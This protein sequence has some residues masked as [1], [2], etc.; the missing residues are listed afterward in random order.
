VQTFAKDYPVLKHPTLT[1]KPV[2]T[3][4][5][6]R[7]VSNEEVARLISVMVPKSS[8]VDYISTEHL[9]AVSD[10][11]S[12]I[13]AR[14]ANLSFSSG[15]F[16]TEFKSAQVT[17][18]PKKPGL[19]QTDPASF[20]PIANL[21]NISKLLERLFLVRLHEHLMESPNNIDELQSAYARGRSC[22]TAL[23]RVKEDLHAIIESGSPALLVSLDISAAFDSIVHETLIERLDIDFGIRDVSLRWLRSFLENR[24][25]YVKVF[26]KA[27]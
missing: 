7:E 26:H 6:L 19:P 2:S 24:T 25:Q 20:R 27:L 10:V 1:I 5:T 8:P 23:L 21:I 3:L 15:V 14:L 17:A 11:I 9:R 13:I 22:E 16:P 18:I 4:T 12:P